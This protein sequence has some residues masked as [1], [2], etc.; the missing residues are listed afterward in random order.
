MRRLILCWRLRPWEASNQRTA[1]SDVDHTDFLCEYVACT[2]FGKLWLEGLADQMPATPSLV[3]VQVCQSVYQRLF[4]QQPRVLAG[5]RQH[6]HH[7]LE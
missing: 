3:D 2:S 1:S 4:N 5:G 6:S 7:P